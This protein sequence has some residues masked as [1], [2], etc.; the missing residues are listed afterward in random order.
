MLT[1][2]AAPPN[3]VYGGISDV[4]KRIFA[5]FVMFIFGVC[6]GIIIRDISAQK[7][8]TVLEKKN[9]SLEE[10]LAT[11]RGYIDSMNFR[12]EMEEG[13]YGKP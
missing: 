2:P 5:L 3:I 9:I 10:E 7:E 12:N 11:T 6:I 4:T 13:K 8:I 1:K